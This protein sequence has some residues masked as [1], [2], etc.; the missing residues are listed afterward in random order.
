MHITPRTPKNAKIAFNNPY[1]EV[2]IPCELVLSSFC[3]LLVQ[4]LRFA[5][6]F[7]LH[8]GQRV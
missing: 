6:R 8:L 1:L 4:I 2:Y 7:S 5:A 3:L